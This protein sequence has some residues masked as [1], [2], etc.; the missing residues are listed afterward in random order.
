MTEAPIFTV[1]RIAPQA[2]GT[3]NYNRHGLLA[4]ALAVEDRHG[5]MADVV[6]WGRDPCRWWLRRGDQTPILGARTLAEATW[7]GEPVML[8]ATPE[9]WLRANRPGGEAEEDHCIAVL[10]WD[11]DLR[12]LFEGVRSVQCETPALGR[13]LHDALHQFD[14]VIEL[15]STGARHAA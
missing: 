12:P 7:H 5:D 2:D 13:C 8:Y 9:S 1:A 6:A 10:R 14:P 15:F 3:F 11:V 4:L